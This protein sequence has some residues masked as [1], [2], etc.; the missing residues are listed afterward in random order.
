MIKD[1]LEYSK[2]YYGL[3]DRIEFALKYLTKTDFA[4]LANGRYELKGSDVFVNIQDYDTKSEDDGKWEA[5]RKYIDIQ[6]L[7]SGSEKI[8]VGYIKDFSSL[9]EYD[10]EKDLEF[11]ETKKRVQFIDLGEKEFMILY[12]NDVHMPQIIRV[13]NSE[14]VRKAVVKIAME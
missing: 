2:N 3:S 7:I 9:I 4:K 8:G 11:L 12:P 1:S 13:A 6:Y 10:A 5:H 14:H